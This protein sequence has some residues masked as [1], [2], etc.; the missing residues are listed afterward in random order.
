MNHAGLGDIRAFLNV[1][2][3]DSVVFDKTAGLEKLSWCSTKRL[4]N[5]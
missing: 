3:C 4:Y 1:S 5:N 2:S